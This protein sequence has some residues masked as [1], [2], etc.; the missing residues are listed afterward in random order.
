MDEQPGL[1]DQYR[2]ASPWPLF[3]AIGL[4][5]AELGILFNWF[6]VAVGGTLL[7]FGSV[8]GILNESGY[9]SK[10]WRVLGYLGVAVL[11]VGGVIVYTQTGDVATRGYAL[12]TTGV[13]SL[14][15]ATAFKL[16]ADA[17]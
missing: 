8:A 17:L 11:L 9:V 4:P 14:V 7:L 16:R 5:I 10:P 6:S 3:I 12:V 1:S 15:G 13:L 2:R